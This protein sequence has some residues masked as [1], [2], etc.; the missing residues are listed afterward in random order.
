MADN[1]PF[2]LIFVS[3]KDKLCQQ[4][5]RGNV[6][7]DIDVY[8]FDM[9]YLGKVSDFIEYEIREPCKKCHPSS[10]KR[11]SDERDCYIRTILKLRNLSNSSSLEFAQYYTHKKC[12][13]CNCVIK[14][15]FAYRYK[16]N[17]E[18]LYTQ[19]I[20]DRIRE[21]DGNFFC[22]DRKMVNIKPAKSGN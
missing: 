5:R 15:G 13:E 9:K 8:T 4:C 17:S 12:T 3:R 2:T 10:N 18:K 22:C 21:Y 1:P 6:Y 20:I 7:S 19:S 16:H 11:P 14:A